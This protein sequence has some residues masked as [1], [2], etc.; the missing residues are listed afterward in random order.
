MFFPSSTTPKVKIG[1][2]PFRQHFYLTELVEIQPMYDSSAIKDKRLLFVDD[3]A[4]LVLLVKD[5]LAL[6]GYVVVTAINGW[7]ALQAINHNIPDLII[8]DV[9]MPRMDGY[10]LLEKVRE[11]PQTYGIPF[12]FL[13]SKGYSQ[14]RIAGLGK[15]ADVYMVKPFEPDE[16]L[17]QIE[18]SLNQ[19]Y[20]LKHHQAPHLENAFS[21]FP[22][23]VGLTA[24]EQHI[25]KLVAKGLIN[26]EIAKNLTI[27]LRTVESHIS[28][29]LSKTGLRNRTELTRWASEH[30]RL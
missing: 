17:A 11:N 12:L 20:R 28:N 7:D 5:Y 15:G 21:L 18:A 16:L 14:D 10:E 22:V 1:H 4:N 26:R 27:S 6:K 29:M 23:D 2:L 8:C 25:I 19:A 3:D 13:S 30:H 9:M 24:S